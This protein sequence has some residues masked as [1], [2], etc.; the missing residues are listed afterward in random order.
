MQPLNL[1]AFQTPDNSRSPLETALCIYLFLK[2]W[3]VVNAINLMLN[4][5]Y[6]CSRRPEFKSQRVGY[7]PNQKLSHHYHP[8]KNQ[9]NS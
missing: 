4:R 9:L 3:F 8:S 2:S 1:R 7:P 6:N 5:K